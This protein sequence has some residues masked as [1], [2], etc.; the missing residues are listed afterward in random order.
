M[1]NISRK[2]SLK[3]YEHFL[4]YKENK[5]FYKD[6]DGISYLYKQTSRSIN[7]IPIGTSHDYFIGFRASGIEHKINFSSK[8]SY[9]VFV[10][11]CTAIDTVIKRFVLINLLVQYGEKGG[12]NIASININSQGITKKKLFGTET[13]P[14]SYFYNCIIDKGNVFLYKRLDN[15]KKCKVFSS[16][17][18]ETMNAVMLPELFKFLFQSSGIIDNTAINELRKVKDELVTKMTSEIKDIINCKNC[19]EPAENSDQKFCGKC[20]TKLE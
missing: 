18:M 10:K 5:I 16:H 4:I 7:F 19:N 2:E 12:L 11:I 14:W 6:F 8:D 9:D 1:P 15:D 20:G 17:S 3:F 13:M